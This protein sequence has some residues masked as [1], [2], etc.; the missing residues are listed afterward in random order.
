MRMML[1][2]TVLGAAAVMVG[3]CG[4]VKLPS[5]PEP[6]DPPAAEVEAVRLVESSEE[7][8]R[9]QLL[10]TLRNRNRFALPMTDASYRLRVGRADY[11]GDI[12][13]NATIPARGEIRL[14][15]P[16]VLVGPAMDGPGEG[17]YA[18][19]GSIEL[20]PPG[21]IRQV[22]YEI[23]VPPLRVPFRGRGSVQVVS[24]ADTDAEV[25]MED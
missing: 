13:P 3:G 1:R 21:Q 6:V 22:M 20:M 19:A 24:G 12:P 18:T 5:L 11:R 23:G 8:S 10:L 14:A 15:L 7:A 9:Y 17:V 25:D 2:I 16:A 4:L